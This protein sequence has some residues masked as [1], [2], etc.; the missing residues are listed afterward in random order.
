M[1]GMWRGGLYAIVDDSLTPLD[2]LVPLADSLVR[3]GATCVQLRVKR[4]S[5]REFLELAEEIRVA[6]E[7]AP[8]VINDR[9]D[10]CALCGSAGLHL[11]QSDIPPRRARELVGADVVIG[12]SCHSLDEVK[13]ANAEPVDYIAF[14]PVFET[15]TKDRPEPTVGVEL[16]AEAVRI[17]RLPVVAIGGINDENL[18][19]IARTGIHSFAAISHLARASDPYC[20]ARRLIEIWR[21][22]AD[23]E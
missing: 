4:L 14:G 7:P 1:G 8:L 22:E 17:S 16:L 6:V 9:A 11:G 18:H 10:I 20:A 23:G 3:A 5:D 12:L 2:G 21:S 19:L 15:T 13:R